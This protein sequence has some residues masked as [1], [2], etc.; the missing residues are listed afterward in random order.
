MS[1]R[2]RARG[3]VSGCAPPARSP[4]LNSRPTAQTPAAAYRRAAG[5]P[6]L[7]TRPGWAIAHAELSLLERIGIGSFGVVYRAS[8]RGQPVAAKLLRN[9]R[10]HCAPGREGER[11]AAFVA[12]MQISAALR[13]PNVVRFLAGCLERGHVAM[14]HELCAHSLH[15]VL[16]TGGTVHVSL[17]LPL[18]V[19]LKWA[20]E[21]ALG[22]AYLHA[23][24]PPI[25]HR[26][27][28]PGNVLLSA[29]W[30][31]KLADFGLA[32]TCERA[33]TEAARIGTAQWTAP[34]LLRQQPH[35]ERAD[36]YSFGV[37]LYEL[38]SRRLPYGHAAQH[39]VEV[40]VI[41]GKQ[42]RPDVAAALG[43]LEPAAPAS[44]REALGALAEVRRHMLAAPL[45]AAPRSARG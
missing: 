3:G 1:A 23:H 12:E 10:S 35:D 42:P 21:V 30:V 29:G 27:L 26:D 20:R 7:A 4:T 37:V 32:R 22:V 24:E 8:W 38:A 45:P 6:P 25:L 33:C 15:D 14:V 44:V 13:H 41:T 2:P 11:A 40:G 18:A 19:Q 39:M 9:D 28:K 5:R 34:E 43:A 16:H 17:Q 36:V 31:A